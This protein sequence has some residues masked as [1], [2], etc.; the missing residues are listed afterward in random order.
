MPVITNRTNFKVLKE[1]DDF[2]FDKQNWMFIQIYAN[3]SITKTCTKNYQT[4]LF[5][6]IFKFLQYMIKV[7]FWYSVSV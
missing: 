2:Q 6:Y 7:E 3:N 4:I 1:T 5:N